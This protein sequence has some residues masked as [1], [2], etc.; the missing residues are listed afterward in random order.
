MLHKL[1]P[2]QMKVFHHFFTI[3]ACS[4]SFLVNSQTVGTIQY[5]SEL[6]QEGY[7]LMAPLGN[8]STY[9]I[10]NCGE[11]I[12]SWDSE[13]TPGNEAFLTEEGN[14]WR[15]GKL[16]GDGLI[17]ARGRGGIIELF[18]WEGELLWSY[19]RCNTEE[20]MHHDFKL[21]PNGNL[22]VLVWDAYTYDQGLAAGGTPE[23]LSTDSGVWSEYLVEI[24]PNLDENNSATE[25]WQW[26]VWD[27][28]V[29]DHD[30]ELPNYGVV[31][32][33]PGKIDLNYR[34]LTQP[35]WLHANAIDYNAELDQIIMSVPHF[36]EF[37]IIDHSLTSEETATEAGDLMYR[38]GNPAAYEN[39]TEDDVKLYFQ[40]NPHWIPAGLRH[41]GKIMVFNNRVPA[42]DSLSSNVIILD[43]LF[44]EAGSYVMSGTT[45]GPDTPA[46]EYQ[47]P[48]EL[49]SPKVSG[50]QMQP[51][52]NLLIC[53][54]T[55]G[56]MLEITDQ[57]EVVWEYKIPITNL[58][59]FYEQGD[60]PSGDIKWLFRGYKYLPDFEG[61]DGKDVTP[62]LPIESNSAQSFC[63]INSVASL[64]NL[65][66]LIYPNPAMDRL[67]IDTSEEI[68]NIVLLSSTGS[69]V[70]QL[71]ALT[72]STIDIS[73]LTAGV[74]YLKLTV[75]GGY[76][77]TSRVVKL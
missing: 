77:V 56:A 23:N 61:F 68:E 30:D 63:A 75:K 8:N 48:P 10:N 28:L 57:D 32:E 21:L 37:W 65:D 42:G 40:H 20:C 24:E 41:E 44:D 59:L 14:L 9:L 16:P 2:D 7:T 55:K 58:N 13:Y 53:S 54:G 1:V 25:I 15:A 50:A 47:L 19:E 27:H 46:Y 64:E 18:N 38:W 5:N 17:G 4:L 34:Q 26:H 45:F 72:V 39:G 60:D 67:N 33:E 51:N 11:I 62:G 43:P 3:I 6:A 35:D 36:D 31:S 22:L 52:G 70:R 12:S 74:Y 71:Q 76:T 66:F 73:D 29:Q 69:R 49:Q